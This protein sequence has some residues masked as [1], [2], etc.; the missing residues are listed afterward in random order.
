MH[1]WPRVKSGVIMAGIAAN[2][3]GFCPHVSRIPGVQER[4][5]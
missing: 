1:K 5:S 4:S 3:A 2:A